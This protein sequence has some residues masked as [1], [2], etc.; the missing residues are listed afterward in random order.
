MTADPE[1]LRRL[2]D[3]YTTEGSLEAVDVARLRAAL[4]TDL[5]SRSA[6]LHVTASALVVHP[7]SRRV[8]L[9]WHERM[10]RWMQVGGHFDPDE[11]DPLSVALREAAEET[12]LTD[13]AP[14][15]AGRGA[16]VQIVIVPVGAGRGEPAHE[17]A[18]IRY[19][20]VTDDPGAVVPET[21][22]A[23]LRWLGVD[24]AGDEVG[25][26]NLRELVRRAAR[27]LG[28]SDP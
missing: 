17:H 13:L 6:P 9:R 22:R 7:A 1:P 20:F 12:G 25:E 2:L 26:D 27:R 24:D 18:D 21:D 5:W 3:A 10:R 11:A 23:R 28:W 15:P 4:D 16:P 8:L 14:A 19:V